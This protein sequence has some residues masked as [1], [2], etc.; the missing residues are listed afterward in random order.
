VEQA[1]QGKKIVKRSDFAPD[2]NLQNL[3]SGFSRNAIYERTWARDEHNPESSL[4]QGTQT[5][6]QNYAG[7][8]V[9]NARDDQGTTIASLE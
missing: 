2:R 5:L 8:G 1:P 6:R 3:N 4:A 9:R 7:L